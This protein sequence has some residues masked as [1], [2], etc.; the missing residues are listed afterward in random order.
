MGFLFTIGSLILSFQAVGIHINPLA[1]KT[2]DFLAGVG[3]MIVYSGAAL[4]TTFVG[5]F[6]RIL[7]IQ[8][9][10][11]VEP[12]ATEPA[13]DQAAQSD[14]QDRDGKPPMPPSTP[15]PSGQEV[16]APTQ[17][18]SLSDR[19]QTHGAVVTVAA[20]FGHTHAGGAALRASAMSSGDAAGGVASA[21]VK[22]GA[23]PDPAESLN[24]IAERLSA[25]TDLLKNLLDRFEKHADESKVGTVGAAPKRPTKLS[26]R[27]PA[28]SKPKTKPGPMPK[29]EPT[30]E[31][32]SDGEPR[33]D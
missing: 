2:D 27:K 5:M 32:R 20:T 26:K 29:P 6:L 9:D 18:I 24:V 10:P 8:F 4:S 28:K 15:L 1:L 23:S 3:Q 12:P 14:P 22:L 30:L 25:A 19:D 33:A 13:L 11:E 16:L 7:Y 31:P 21:H 17:P